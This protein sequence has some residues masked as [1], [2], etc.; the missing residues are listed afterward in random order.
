MSPPA[1]ELPKLWNDL[2]LRPYLGE[3]ARRHGIVETLA[4]PSMRDLPPLRIETLFVSPALATSPASADSDPATWPSGANLFNALQASPQLVVLGDPGGGK[5]TLANWLAWRLASGLVAPLPPLLTER[6]PLPCILREMPPSLYTENTS[7]PDLA[8]FLAER[9]L[10]DKADSVL[11][12]SLRARV[13]AG[14]YVLILDGID[15]IAVP[16]RKIVAA[17]L[18]QANQDD[19]CALA[20]SRLVGYDDYPVD[21]EPRELSELSER[22][23]ATEFFLEEALTDNIPAAIKAART[24][25]HTEEPP[26]WAQ[27]RYLLPFDQPRIAAFVENWYRQRCGTEHEARQ[28]SGDLLTQLNKS[29]VTQRLART[30]NLL[31]LMA[32]VF[33][34][35]AHLPDGK[36]LLYDEIANAYINTIDKQRKILPGDALAPYSWKERRAWLAYV[37]FQMQLLRDDP[38][39]SKSNKQMEQGVLVEEAQVKNWLAEAMQQTGVEQPIK[40]AAEFLHWVARRS[41]LLLPRGEGRY[42]F[43]HLS[44]QE[45]FCACHLYERIVSPAYMRDRLPEDAPVTRDKLCAWGHFNTWRETLVYLF[46]ILSAE[47]G[48]EWVNDLA[49]TLF[50]A[51]EEDSDLHGAL[52]ALAGRA[53]ADRHIRLG[54]NWKD[55]LADRCSTAAYW[56]K[57]IKNKGLLLSALWKK[58]IK[59]EGLVLSALADAGYAAFV[60]MS[61]SDGKPHKTLYDLGESKSRLRVLI[62]TG[63]D[64]ADITQLA[65]LNYLRVLSLSDTLVADVAPLAGL[66]KLQYLNLNNTQVADVAP[67][68]GLKNLQVLHL[69]NTPVADVAPLAGLENLQH[70]HLNNTPVA[71]VAPLAGLEKLQ[72]LDLSN[73]QVADV[74]PLAGLKQLQ[75]FIDGKFIKPAAGEN[76]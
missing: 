16:H 61:S 53:L 58:L 19:A 41:G 73:T 7:L 6:V 52:A 54:R 31:S 48:M 55:K 76:I 4:L 59:G 49:T 56:E 3:I 44:F 64:S 63:G 40:T 67:L 27:L 39:N 75:V 68:A 13:A 11:L 50:G 74:A 51:L 34:E 57:F 12:T 60:G 33:R 25:K 47:H 2:S 23:I 36:A 1:P 30:P 8:Q 35:R 45:Y 62:F 14:R 17:W 70:L 32:I 24:G 46:E 26:R 5:T 66:E 20:T 22:M 69:S 21:G 72:Y 9:L 38:Q 18:R 10:G 43:V 28:K 71:D 42:A 29:D 65:G 15:E 37:G